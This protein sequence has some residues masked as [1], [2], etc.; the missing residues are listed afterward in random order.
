MIIFLPLG[1]TSKTSTSSGK[2]WL[3]LFKVTITLLIVDGAPLTM[4]FEG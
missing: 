1:D 2:V 4:M 3:K